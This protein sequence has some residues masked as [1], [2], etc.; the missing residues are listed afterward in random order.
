MYRNC[1]NANRMFKRRT[2]T[3]IHAL[4]THPAT[5]CNAS[6]KK[7]SMC[8]G[9]GL[10]GD[11]QWSRFIFLYYLFAVRLHQYWQPFGSNQGHHSE[12]RPTQAW[13]FVQVL[14]RLP[15]LHT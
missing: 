11:L 9:C 2:F 13:R 10:A 5:H 7:R 15:M 14:W 4:A 6:C 8:G 1:S 3:R 12:K